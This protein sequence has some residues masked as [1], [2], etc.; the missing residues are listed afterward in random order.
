M[1]DRPAI[2]EVS[3]VNLVKAFI[4]IFDFIK[5]YSPNFDMNSYMRERLNKPK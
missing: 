2:L 4:S 3:D 1:L 5:D